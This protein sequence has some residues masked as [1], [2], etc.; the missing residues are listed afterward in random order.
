MNPIKYTRIL[1]VAGLAV[2]ISGC[3]ASRQA[4]TAAPER[5]FAEPAAGDSPQSRYISA[6]SQI[7]VEERRRSGVPASITLAQGMLESGNGL[8][9]LAV[10]GN[11]H[12]GIK[13]HD[14]KGQKIYFDDD[15]K[16]ECFRKYRSPEE[17]F[18]DHSDFLR[19]RDRYKFLFD[20]NVTDYRS[21]AYG[22]KKAGY[23]TDPAYPQKLI[24]LVETYGLDRFDKP[25]R[26]DRKPADN[27]ASADGMS[28]AD[29]A[30]PQPPAE[31][32]APVPVSDRRGKAVSISLTRQLYSQN[33]VPF[34]Y[35]AEGET[36]SEIAGRYNL[37]RK[38]ILRYNDLAQ[39]EVLMPGTVV[40]LQPK[41][42]RAAKHVDKY[43]AEGGETVR[44]ISQRYAVRL[45]NL[46]RLNGMDA[47]RELL[48]GEMIN[49]R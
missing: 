41:K 28:D 34:V 39:D 47:D 6:Y 38:E 32:E 13:C 37:F 10:R 46:L 15:R 48:E 14:W 12:F 25:S 2:L 3:G 26:H 11:N 36:Y 7:A 20:F 33:K 19:Y 21:W 30:V 40:Y 18:R 43:V 44:D 4:S 1:F 22:L 35:S 24:S 31:L 5:V 17:S 8:S 9:E 42:S 45:K 23:A 16:G 27:A 29:V 49:L